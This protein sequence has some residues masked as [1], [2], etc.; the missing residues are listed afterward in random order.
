MSKR[1]ADGDSVTKKEKNVPHPPWTHCCAMEQFPHF[2]DQFIV[3]F[4]LKMHL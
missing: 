3:R 4:N 2:Y 1:K